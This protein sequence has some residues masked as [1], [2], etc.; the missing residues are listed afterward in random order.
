MKKE[1]ILIV[2]DIETN[3]DIL[4]EI[5]GYD[6]D[7]M[8]AL[9]GK[10][11]LKQAQEYHPDLILLDIMMPE[12]DGY[13]VCKALKANPHTVNI[14]IIFNTARTDENSIEKAYTIGGIDYI[15]K[16]FKPKEIKV[17]VEIQLK[18]KRAL[19][20]L[21]KSKRQL[22]LLASLDPLTKLYNRR[23]FIIYSN[24][25]V[26]NAK[27]HNIPTSVVM[28]DLDNFKRINDTYGHSVGDD[29]LIEIANMLKKISTKDEIICRYGGEEFAILLK[30]STIEETKEFANELKERMN[31]LKI[32]TKK[33]TISVT[34]SIGISM[35]DLEKEDSIEDALNRADNAMYKVKRTT[36]NDIKVQI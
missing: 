27:K 18:M 19:K 14:P 31:T 29:V 5:L 11:A 1:T 3:I 6:Y 17:R 36:K 13:E 8:V 16:P 10:S 4:N 2:D 21:E 26:S 24:N 23:Y 25:I 7:I 32:P 34:A 30:N 33:G 22:A 12:M 35:V 28:F 15:C 9:D 20:A